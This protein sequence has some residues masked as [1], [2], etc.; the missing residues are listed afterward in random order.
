LIV[1]GGGPIGCE[2]GQSFARLGSQVIQVQS[3][4]QLLNREDNEIIKI[5][6]ERFH[7]EGVDVRLNT[8]AV[9]VS[10]QDGRKFLVVEKEG[11]KSEIE[12][13]QM[14]VAVGRQPRVKG[15]GLEELGIKLT[16]R[17]AVEVDEYSRT[18]VKNIFA[19][20]DVTSPYQFT[21]IA[22]HQAWYCAVNALFQPWVKFKVNLSIVPW[23]TFTDPE[24]A[25]VGLNEKDAQAKKVPYEVTIYPLEDLDRAIADEEDKGVVKILTE[26]GKDKV[27]GVTICGYHAGDLLSEFVLAKKYGLGLNRIM[28]AIHVYPTMGEANKYAAG[29]WKKAHAP[30]GILNLLGKVHAFRRGKV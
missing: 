14:L 16:E 19:C 7:E 22:A 28:G 11:K 21:H 4:S 9:E 12:F 29:V 2:L 25:R 23:C 26:P 6:E 18:S 20:G 15:Y 30:H 5:I 1:L 17:G 24:V 8:K 3:A 13:D 27:L 10:V